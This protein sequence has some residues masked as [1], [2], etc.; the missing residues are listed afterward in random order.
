MVFQYL[1]YGNCYSEYPIERLLDFWKEDGK[2]CSPL[3]PVA[4]SHLLVAG[5]F[6]FG[7]GQLQ[8]GFWCRS[9]AQKHGSKSS[10]LFSNTKPFLLFKQRL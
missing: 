1:F 9:R 10:Y 2:N 8:S 7:Y 6:D 3:L 5:S 4:S